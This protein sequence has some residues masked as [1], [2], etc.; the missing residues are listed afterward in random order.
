MD[1]SFNG[2][3]R[4]QTPNGNEK[5]NFGRVTD[6]LEFGRRNIRASGIFSYRQGYVSSGSDFLIWD[7]PV[8]RQLSGIRI[9]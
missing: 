9:Y 2:L 7:D 1:D 3:L 5:P 8:V 6:T 4:L